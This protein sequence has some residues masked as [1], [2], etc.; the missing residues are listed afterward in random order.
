M[1]LVYHGH[2]LD[3]YTG[4]D[5]PRDLMIGDDGRILAIEEGLTPARAAQMFGGEA[6]AFD[7]A[8]LI[9]S[10]GLV[11]VHVHFRDPGQTDREDLSTGARA[12]AAGGFTTVVCM[13]NTAPT[14]DNVDTL[15]YVLDKA[16]KIGTV[17]ILQTCAVTRG[18]GGR[19]LTDFKALLDAGAAGFTDDGVNLTDAGLCREAMERAAALGT[20]LSFHEE[21]RTLVPSP[22]VNYGSAAAR[23]FGVAGARPESEECMVAR[24]IAL[25]L[26]TGARVSFQHISSAN[27]VRL[28]RMGKALGAKIY[29]EATPHHIS[30]TEEAVLEHG[31]YARMNP[32]LRR[33]EDRLALIGG[34]CDGTV[35]MIATDHAPHTAADKAKDFA[36]APSGI[37]GLET[38]FSVCNTY[39]VRA[40][41]LN[42]MELV[43]RMSQNPAQIYGLHGKSIEVGNRAELMLADW[44]AEVKYTEYKSKSNNSPYT[45]MP[46]WGEVRATVMGNRIVME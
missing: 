2:I 7:A 39:L 45:N 17:N 29:A 25:A 1:L 10:P 12:A 44:G 13:A 42:R 34:L 20:L 24:D 46:L 28:I 38:A 4:L 14:V 30:L 32:P 18:L 40:G 43:R 5:A 31:T 21:D 37:I 15:R 3:P 23:R 33:E 6:E 36:H 27:S 8:G 19:E 22:G 11:D 26:R 41:H 9:V 16:A 35:D